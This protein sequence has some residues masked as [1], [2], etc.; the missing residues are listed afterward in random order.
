MARQMEMILSSTLRA[1]QPGLRGPVIYPL[2]STAGGAK[3]DRTLTMVPSL[4]R[5]LMHQALD[6]VISRYS[7][8]L[9]PQI[10]RLAVT[11]SVTMATQE[12]SL[13][14]APQ[15]GKMT[16]L[17][18]VRLQKAPKVSQR[19]AC[20]L[21]NACLLSVTVIFIFSLPPHSVTF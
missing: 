8:Y 5:S 20:H 7:R 11:L 14:R 19:P 1:F 17:F 13:L 6:L 21:C 2:F 3:R 10:R 9:S 12:C 4:N 15:A 16:R 18:P